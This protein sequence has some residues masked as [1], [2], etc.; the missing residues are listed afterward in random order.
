MKMM[1]SLVK[2]NIFAVLQFVISMVLSCL[3]APYVIGTILGIIL[4]ILGK[5]NLIM[6]ADPFK[7]GL[8]V[9]ITNC[10]IGYKIYKETRKRIKAW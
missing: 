8:A 3:T 10:F 2:S 9:I 5:Q 1:K 4:G 7:L 6:N